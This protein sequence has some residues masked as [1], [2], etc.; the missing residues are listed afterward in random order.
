MCARREGQPRITGVY[1]G[2]MEPGAMDCAICAMGCLKRIGPASSRFRQLLG[3]L[4]SLPDG[5]KSFAL[6]HRARIPTGEPVGQ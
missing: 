5:E 4:C 1:R 6:L 3:G 2:Q